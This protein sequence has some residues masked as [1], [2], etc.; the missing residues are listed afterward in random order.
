MASSEQSKRPTLDIE[1]DWIPWSKY[2]F[3]LTDEYRVKRYID[4]DIVAPGLPSEPT[5]PS[6]TMIR[7]TT[8]VL[9]NDST[10]PTTTRPTLFSDLIVGERE[11]L[12]WLNVEYNDNKRIYHKCDRSVRTGLDSS[13]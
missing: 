13:S 2:I 4:P 6:P 11:Q 12:R 3:I 10:Q 7:P 8:S 1:K 5:R 9:A